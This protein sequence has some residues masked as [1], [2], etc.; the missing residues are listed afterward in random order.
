MDASIDE[1]LELMYDG[2]SKLLGFTAIKQ[3]RLY[4]GIEDPCFGVIRGFSV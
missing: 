1:D 2:F 4:I 3:D